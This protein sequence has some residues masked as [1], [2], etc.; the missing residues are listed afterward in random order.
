MGKC[1]TWSVRRP[2]AT[3]SST[4]RLVAQLSLYDTYS[5]S[6]VSLDDLH[7]TDIHVCSVCSILVNH[8]SLLYMSPTAQDPYQSSLVVGIYST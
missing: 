2:L 4:E 1:V 8:K 6:N 5:G 7:H 3:S